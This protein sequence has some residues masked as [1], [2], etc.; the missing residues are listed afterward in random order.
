MKSDIHLVVTDIWE[1]TV[2]LEKMARNYF[3]KENYI[4]TS[5]VG[6]VTIRDDEESILDDIF[7]DKKTKEKVESMRNLFL[8]VPAPSYNLGK[9]VEVA[10]KHFPSVNPV[11][12]VRNYSMGDEQER[13]ID[14]AKKHNGLWIHGGY[15]PEDNFNSIK[16]LTQINFENPEFII[17][18]IKQGISSAYDVMQNYKQSSPKLRIPK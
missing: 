10:Q 3:T 13:M 8:N 16:M 2:E 7:T 14:C 17:G 6:N 1:D 12:F 18:S 15:K 9:I 4:F 11:F 5:R